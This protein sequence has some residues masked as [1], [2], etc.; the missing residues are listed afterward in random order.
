MSDALWPRSIV[1]AALAMTIADCS[2][3]TK[4]PAATGP[5]PTAGVSPAIPRTTASAAPNP[6]APIAAPAAMPAPGASGDCPFAGP[7]QN[8]AASQGP[9]VR[10]YDSYDFKVVEAGKPKSVT[11]TGQF[12]EQIYRLKP[13]SPC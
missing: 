7:L 2:P 12:C 6:P 13:R 11:K 4:N 10:T 9:I 8:F 1:I 5:T 3:P